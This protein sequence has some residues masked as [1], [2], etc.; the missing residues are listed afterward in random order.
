MR[1]DTTRFPRSTSLSLTA[2]VL[3][4][5]LVP[6]HGRDLWLPAVEIRNASAAR[7]PA[8]SAAVAATVHRFHAA[9]AAGDSAAVS[10]LLAPGAVILESGGVE[11]RE[12]YLGGHLRGD[13]AFAQAVASE[14]GPIG[15]RI[16][17][18]VAWATSTSSMSGEF[19]GREVN[20]NGAELMVLLRT[21]GQWR[22]AAIHWSSRARAVR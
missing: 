11:T 13:I 22:I 3:V 4:T 7:Q 12:E 9:L 18:D 17:G 20:S 21:D 8:D 2:V 19:R 16:A 10:S 15:V 5:A 6:L 14:R 1:P